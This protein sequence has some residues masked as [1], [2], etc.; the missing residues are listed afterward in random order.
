MKLSRTMI[1]GLLVV[2][3]GLSLTNDGWYAMDNPVIKVRTKTIS[4]LAERRLV[5]A[6]YGGVGLSGDIYLTER[7][8]TLVDKT[9]EWEQYYNI[10]TWEIFVLQHLTNYRLPGESDTVASRRLLGSLSLYLR[11]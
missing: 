3:S 11:S 5:F 9:H 1:M 7:G 10:D 4:A 8:R 6:S 2:E